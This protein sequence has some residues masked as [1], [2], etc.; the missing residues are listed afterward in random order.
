MSPEKRIIDDLVILGRAVPEQIKNGRVTVCAAGYSKTFGFTRIFPTK[1]RMPLKRWSIVKVPVERDPRDT[2]S[3]SWKIQGS[4]SEWDRLSEKVQVV[5]VLKPKERLNLI[6]NLTDNCVKDFNEVK[7]SLGIVKP[8]IKKCY[9]CPAEK[10]DPTLQ[11][12]LFGAF[13]P[14]IKKQYRQF[15][16]I[17][18]RCL[19]C[20]AKRH[21]DQTVLE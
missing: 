4:K 13:L 8:I 20:R 16:K 2:R 19:G 1:V 17:Q 12:T 11:A 6:A 10:F 21:H 7:R 15:P 5:G 18:Y 3:E 14:S 9:F